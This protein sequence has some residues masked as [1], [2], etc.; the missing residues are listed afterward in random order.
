MKNEKTYQYLETFTKPD[1]AWPDEIAAPGPVRDFAHLKRFCTIW[2][3]FPVVVPF[4]AVLRS[5]VLLPYY[6]TRF[7]V[8]VFLK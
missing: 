8:S 4:D 2:R 3:R 7:L 5:T 6:R 1:A